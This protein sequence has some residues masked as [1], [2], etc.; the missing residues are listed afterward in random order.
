MI[1][2]YLGVFLPLLL[3]NPDSNKLAIAFQSTKE[4]FNEVYVYI[5]MTLSFY[6]IQFITNVVMLLMLN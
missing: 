1:T 2:V 5:L 4:E 6:V 3:I